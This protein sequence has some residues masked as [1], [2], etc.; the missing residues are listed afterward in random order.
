MCQVW[1]R[2]FGAPFSTCACPLACKGLVCQ[3]SLT[4][5]NLACTRYL[6]RMQKQEQL[7]P[8]SEVHRHTDAVQA[9]FSLLLAFLTTF[10]VVYGLA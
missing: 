1:L 5:A 4:A 2:G 3:S 8:I 10:K 7:V 9:L 6:P